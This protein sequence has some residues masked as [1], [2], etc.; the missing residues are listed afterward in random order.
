MATSRGE[1]ERWGRGARERQAG[2]RLSL[3][4]LHAAAVTPSPVDT[5]CA[6]Q[7][8]GLSPCS[9]ALFLSL[10]HAPP[11]LTHT[12]RLTHSP[13]HTHRL[14]HSPPNTQPHTPSHTP[15]SPSL[16]HTHPHILLTHLNTSL[17][18]PSHTPQTHT[19]FTPTYTLTH[20]HPHT[21]LTCTHTHT[22]THTTTEPTGA[23]TQE[24]KGPRGSAHT[25]GMWSVWEQP[26]VPT[27]VSH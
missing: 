6:S 10:R 21:L 18:H 15:H 14:T 24:T 23:Q 16:T 26:R 22:Y 3:I 25:P 5:L 19:L 1:P 2:A 7:T 17:A 8:N 9:A 4:Q 11:P 12:H 13:P 27:G 20:T